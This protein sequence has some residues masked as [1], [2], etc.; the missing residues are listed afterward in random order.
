MLQHLCVFLMIFVWSSCTSKRYTTNEI[1]VDFIQWGDRLDK[2]AELDRTIDCPRNCLRVY[3]LSTSGYAEFTEDYLLDM[4]WRN[5]IEATLFVFGENDSIQKQLF[6]KLSPVD[7]LALESIIAKTNANA[8]RSLGCKD[9]SASFT[10]LNRFKY[11]YAANEYFFKYSPV[12]Y[13]TDH[14]DFARY[15]R[16]IIKDSLEIDF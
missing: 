3:R 4:K 15:L 12:N 16:K 13:G 5:S 8:L 2:S 11:Q 6:F 14:D 1:P 10:Y 7:S 9:N